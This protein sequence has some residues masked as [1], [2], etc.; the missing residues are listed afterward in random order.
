MAAS[1]EVKKVNVSFFKNLVNRRVP[2]ILGI[3][4]GVSWGIIQFMEWL[5]NRYMFSP[6]LIDLA[7]AILLSLIPSS[8]IVAYYH[9]L[10]GRNKWVKTEKLGIP[11]NVVI[12]AVIIA[13]L[14]QGK[15]LGSVSRTVTLEDETGKKIERTV[16]KS[17]FRKK[18]ALFYFKN[19][20]G[21]PSLDW[22]RYGISAMLNMDLAQD[23]FIEI[24]SPGSVGLERLDFS[25]YDKIKDAG[26]KDCTGLPLT[27]RRDIAREMHMDF[28]LSGKLSKAGENYVVEYS[29]YRTK[30]ARLLNQSDI[31]GKDPFKLIDDLTLRLKGELEI[32][33]AHIEEVGDLPVEE[34]F[35]ASLPAARLFTLG[36]SAMMFDQDWKKAGHYL[37]EATREDPAFAQAYRLLVAVYSLTNQGEKAA[38]TY[39]PVMKYIHKFPERDQLYVKTGYYIAAKKDM[40]RGLAVLEMINKLYPDDVAAYTFKAALLFVKDRMDD[41]V[42]AYRRVLEIDPRRYEIFQKIGELYEIKGDFEQALDNY[43]KFAGHF[44]GNPR[45]FEILGRL[46]RRTRDFEQAKEYYEK[47]LLL[48]PGNVSALAVLAGIEADM[49]NPD[50]ADQ[51]FE[52]ALQSAKTAKDRFTVSEESIPF[53]QRRGRMKKVLEHGIMKINALDEY[54][55]PL[56]ALKFRAYYLVEYYIMAGEEKEAFRLLASLES[57]HNDPDDVTIPIGYIKAYTKLGKPDEAEKKMSDIRDLVARSGNEQQVIRLQSIQGKIHE[58]Q[59]EYT[60]ALKIYEARFK[61]T[62][63][64]VAYLLPIGRCYRHLKQ[65]EKAEE[66]LRQHL[67]SSPYSPKSNYELAL[68]YLDM[69]NKEKAAEHLKIAVEIWKDADPGYNPAQSAK[70]RLAEL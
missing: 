58:L 59:G 39:E 29:L 69:G 5:V 47:A 11:L 36:L 65:Y 67:K 66:Y 7:L 54:S 40:T 46:S 50:K 31:R 14:F 61:K 4:I 21:D 34:M 33:T 1:E 56:V 38:E 10:P 30:N 8:C 9:G 25:I 62:P 15:D 57:K 3:Y 27:L 24:S 45:S 52:D 44:P 28:F 49:G 32:P 68:L 19:E 70:K 42:G 6:H 2:Q 20:T 37:T 17:G 22:M 41:A 13:V 43:K 53:Y 23:M 16:P 51:L 64:A 55:V 12:T 63:A 18:I 48:E 26:Y 35:T 60:E